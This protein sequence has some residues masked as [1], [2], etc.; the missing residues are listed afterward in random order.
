MSEQLQREQWLC[1]QIA[2]EIYAVPV[3]QVKAIISY[4]EPAPVPGSMSYIE[5]VLNVRGNIVTILSSRQLLGIKQ[6]QS[7]HIVIL[8]TVAGLVGITV[9][10]VNKIKRLNHEDMVPTEDNADYSPIKATI[11]HQQ[12]LLILTDFDRCVKQL[13]NYE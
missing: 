13:E 9:D 1:F 10:Q 12:Q 5:G 11:Y 7:D 6:A 8:E 2:G 4:I 3:N